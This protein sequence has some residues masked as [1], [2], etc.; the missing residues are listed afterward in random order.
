[1]G[2][3]GRLNKEKEVRA[4]E[5]VQQVKVLAIKPGKMSLIP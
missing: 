5:M 1:M 3:C 2:Y 4:N